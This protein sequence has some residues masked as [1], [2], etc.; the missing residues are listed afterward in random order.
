MA[1]VFLGLFVLYFIKFLIKEFKKKKN[2]KYV[3]WLLIFI[4]FSAFVKN[5]I[6]IITN[7]IYFNKYIIKPKY[8]LLQKIKNEILI[9]DCYSITVDDISILHSQHL[10][11]ISKEDLKIFGK[12]N[13]DFVLIG[14]SIYLNIAEGGLYPLKGRVNNIILYY[15]NIDKNKIKFEGTCDLKNKKVKR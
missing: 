12:T 15:N 7:R 4:I 3:I 9:N 6:L 10:K 1:D 13:M 2:V 14:K 8:E 11:N 5:N